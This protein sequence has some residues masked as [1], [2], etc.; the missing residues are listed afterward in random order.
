MQSCHQLHTFKH[1]PIFS[2]KLLTLQTLSLTDSQNKIQSILSVSFLLHFNFH[3]HLEKLK[4]SIKSQVSPHKHIETKQDKTRELLLVN[5]LPCPPVCLIKLMVDARDRDRARG[6][7]RISYSKN[8]IQCQF[9]RVLVSSTRVG[10]TRDKPLISQYC[11][12]ASI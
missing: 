7:N 12:F 5:W 4:S 9:T 8:S 10:V 6:L 11:C 3:F 1:S 2:H